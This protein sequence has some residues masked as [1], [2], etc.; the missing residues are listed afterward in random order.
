VTIRLQN[1]ESTEMFSRLIHLRILAYPSVQEDLE[2]EP[3]LPSH[4]VS[5]PAL[6][7]TV[8]L[9]QASLDGGLGS[10]TARKCS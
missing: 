7:L 1:S 2:H 4:S 10:F 8:C 3:G 6:N 9:D 5:H